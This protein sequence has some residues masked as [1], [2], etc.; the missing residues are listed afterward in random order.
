[1]LRELTD[2]SHLSI[3]GTAVRGVEIYVAKLILFFFYSPSGMDVMRCVRTLVKCIEEGFWKSEVELGAERAVSNHNA[4]IKVP[5]T[6]KVGFD[7]CSIT[8][9]SRSRLSIFL[10][11]TR[12]MCNGI[13]RCR[14]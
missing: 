12:G 4:M 9:R 11:P 3:L 2:L 10:W 1:M 6:Q 14:F 5:R 13:K 7:A 8:Y